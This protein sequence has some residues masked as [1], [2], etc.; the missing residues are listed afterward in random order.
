MT[1]ICVTCY[2]HLFLVFFFFCTAFSRF[3]IDVLYISVCE[4]C[5]GCRCGV[6]GGNCFLSQYFI[7]FEFFLQLKNT[8]QK[9]QKE[10]YFLINFSLISFRIDSESVTK[11]FQ[12]H[13]RK[14]KTQVKKRRKTKT[15]PSNT[16]ILS[17]QNFLSFLIAFRF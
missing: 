12:N 14:V 11:N 4:K 17:N 5:E 13:L 16:A 10:K 9:H 7:T 1:V 3:Y 8:M 2:N 6:E 15:T